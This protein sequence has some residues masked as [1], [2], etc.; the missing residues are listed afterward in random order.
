MGLGDVFTA[1]CGKSSDNIRLPKDATIVIGM[2]VGTHLNDEIL[3][4]LSQLIRPSLDSEHTFVNVRIAVETKYSLSKIPEHARRANFSGGTLN[5]A[6]KSEHLEEGQALRALFDGRF[7]DCFEARKVPFEGNCDVPFVS[8]VKEVSVKSTIDNVGTYSIY[9]S[10]DGDI[11]GFVTTLKD[12][13][14]IADIV[15]THSRLNGV[16][17]YYKET[18]QGLLPF[19]KETYLVLNPEYGCSISV[20]LLPRRV[21]M[22]DRGEEERLYC[23]DT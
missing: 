5:L 4:F 21:A 7:D 12:I 2:D 20:D 14:G 6:R 10:V 18:L 22:F 17:A 11:L 16:R 13:E 9:V 1:L 3:R 23:S 19:P 8:Y 15:V